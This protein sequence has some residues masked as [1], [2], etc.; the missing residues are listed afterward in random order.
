[1]YFYQLYILFDPQVQAIFL[2]SRFVHY[3][4]DYYRITEIA[5]TSVNPIRT[6]NSFAYSKC[7][8]CYLFG[9]CGAC[10]LTCSSLQMHEF[11]SNIGSIRSI[12]IKATEISL[13]FLHYSY[14]QFFEL[15]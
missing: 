10:H 13:A 7:E 5:L 12:P 4:L 11:H 6:K 2:K 8:Q 3:L 9:Y 15:R 1:M 14:G